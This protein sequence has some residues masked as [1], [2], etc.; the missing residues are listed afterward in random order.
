MLICLDKRELIEVL[1]FVKNL[2]TRNKQRFL[3]K[4][5][6]LNEFT[7]NRVQD[8]NETLLEQRFRAK[9]IIYDQD[10]ASESFYIVKRGRICI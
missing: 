7:Y 6:F 4:C 3:G 2:D 5:Q 9:E 8:V 1:Q 10:A